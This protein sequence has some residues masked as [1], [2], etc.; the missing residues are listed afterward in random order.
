MA[1]IVQHVLLRPLPVVEQDRVVV[2]WGVFQSS[3]F[4][5]VPL[6]HATMLEVA[7]RTRVFERIAGVDYNVPGRMSPGLK[8]AACPPGLASSAGSSSP[9]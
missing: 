5:H 4:G 9:H 2:S 3:G 6:T 8:A 1:G 7:A